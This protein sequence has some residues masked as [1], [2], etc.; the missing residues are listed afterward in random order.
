MVRQADYLTGKET[1]ALFMAIRDRAR[2]RGTEAGKARSTRDR[3]LFRVMFEC[4][5]R[6]SEIGLLQKSDWEDRDGKLHVRRAKNSISH[7]YMLTAPAAAALRA[8]L[9]V[10]GPA[11]GALF[12]SQVPRAGG[13]GMNP[14]QVFR[15]CQ[16]YCRAALIPARKSHPQALRDSRGMDIR[17]RGGD[18]LAIRERLGHRAAKSAFRYL[19]RQPKV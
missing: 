9:K 7:S 8:W 11:P 1:E 17:A 10:R 19:I 4:A 3:A 12:P 5:L 6:P 14:S 16:A 13:L 18:A 15:L 2:A